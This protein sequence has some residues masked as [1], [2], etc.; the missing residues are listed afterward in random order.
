MMSS[1]QASENT[2]IRALFKMGK[3]ILFGILI[4]SQ[5]F[6]SEQSLAGSF[7][8]DNADGTSNVDVAAATSAVTDSDTAD[9]P[10]DVGTDA[11]TAN[12]HEMFKVDPDS[13]KKL[14]EQSKSFDL[15]NISVGKEH[16]LVISG[17]DTDNNLIYKVID[18]LMKT[19]GTLAILLI[20]IAGY[21][22]ITSQG[23]ENQLQKGKTIVTYTILGLAVAL[24]SYIMVQIVMSAAFNIGK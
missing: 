1:L 16:E 7:D 11:V 4:C 5:L 14:V 3:K 10:D 13:L 2:Q 9:N 23:D 6:L 24:G 8:D 15:T 17:E 12:E 19:I 22:I 20:V 21:F 18:L